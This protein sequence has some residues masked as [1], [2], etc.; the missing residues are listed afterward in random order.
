[1]L[2]ATFW[3]ISHAGVMQACMAAFLFSMLFEQD[4]SISGPVQ[5]LHCKAR[6]GFAISEQMSHAQLLVPMR[7][8]AG[9]GKT[10]VT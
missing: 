5:T 4:E 3:Q 1:M 2:N 10:S 7:S 8:S 9:L 6:L